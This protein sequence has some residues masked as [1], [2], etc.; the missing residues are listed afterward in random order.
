MR[1][2][3]CEAEYP[4]E[5]AS[6]VPWIP[7]YGAEIPIHRVPSGLPGPGRNGV[8]V[9]RP[10]GGRRIPPRVP[11]QGHDLVVAEGRRERGLTGGH[12]EPADELRV[13]EEE[14]PVRPPHDHDRLVELGRFDL[15]SR[16]ANGRRIGAR[17]F[18]AN[19]VRIVRPVA[20]RFS[21]RPSSDLTARGFNPSTTI[22]ASRASRSTRR[23]SRSTYRRTRAWET[24]T[25]S[26][27]IAPGRATRARRIAF[28][29]FACAPST[30]GASSPSLRR[31]RRAR[32]A[33][34][35][36]SAPPC[37]PGTA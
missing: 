28:G 1:M 16:T 33:S 17:L 32:A 8:G 26:G 30:S 15:R 36:P 10:V 20:R 13:V 25:S 29:T 9:L 31:R 22:R 12:A 5:A 21:C 14:E 6:G 19:A 35:T 2:H 34:R 23:P 7:T 11:L 37:S 3:P 27:T 4:I 18:V 24:S